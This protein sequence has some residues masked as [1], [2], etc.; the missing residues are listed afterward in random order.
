MIRFLC[1]G[2][3]DVA[4]PILILAVGLTIA[5]VVYCFGEDTYSVYEKLTTY[6][7]ENL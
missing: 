7:E 1:D 6:Q 4:L 3:I 5:I 2:F